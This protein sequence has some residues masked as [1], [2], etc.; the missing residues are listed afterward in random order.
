[1]RLAQIQRHVA[2]M[3]ELQRIVGAMRAIASMRMQEAVRALSSVRQYGS[4]LAEAVRQ[5]LAIA[6]DERAR[7]G[8]PARRGGRRAI[9][10]FTSEHGFVGGFNERLLEAANPSAS[11]TLVIAGSRGAAL[12]AER[13]IP[14]QS[15]HAMATHLA[16]VPEVVRRVQ[17]ALYPA[18]AAGETAYAEVVFGRYQRSGATDVQRRRLFPLEIEPGGRR[19]GPAPLHD[20]SAAELLERMTAEYILARLT[21]AAVESLAAENG[22]RFAAMEAAHDNVGERLQKLRLQASQARQEEVTTELLD[23]VIG[24]LAVS[25]IRIFADAAHATDALSIASRR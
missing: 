19:G 5:A 10:V 3:E 6:A 21:E 9:V 8:E 23:L 11:D 13:E 7:S 12:A 24:E 4:A 1:M 2:S 22:A 14:V 20:L 15:A 25:P 17:D 18:I 16:S